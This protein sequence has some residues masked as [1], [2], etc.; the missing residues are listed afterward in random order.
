ML[1]ASVGVCAVMAAHAQSVA[2]VD[3]EELFRLH[4]NT[5]SDKKLLEQTVKDFRAENDELR[6][7]LETVRD[8]FEKIRKEAQDPA[9]SEKARKSAEER[10]ARGGETLM[11]AKN[12]AQEKMQSRQDQL[13]DMQ[14]RM[15]KK[16][17]AELRELIGKYAEEKKIPLVLAAGQVM[18]NDKTIDITEAILKQFAVLP[19]PRATENSAKPAPAKGKDAGTPATT[20]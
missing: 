17:I 2:V 12:A 13:A 16:T 8:E 9:L 20:K 4:P 3:M 14:A 10:V 11:M 7:K 15:Q 5:A 18:Y 19:A 1:V 6:Q